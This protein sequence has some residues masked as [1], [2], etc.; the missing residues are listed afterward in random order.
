[1]A[2]N[3]FRNDSYLPENEITANFWIVLTNQLNIS[4]SEKL[5]TDAY[6][7]IAENL[8]EYPFSLTDRIGSEIN[9][10]WPADE[11]NHPNL[12][13][14]SVAIQETCASGAFNNF[15]SLKFVPKVG[16]TFAPNKPFPLFLKR[17]LD[18][19][20]RVALRS[21]SVNPIRSDSE[22]RSSDSDRISDS[23]KSEVPIRGLK[24]ENFYH[25]DPF[26]LRL[27]VVCAQII[28]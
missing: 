6:F 13:L 8:P 22:I 26:F 11:H 4:F 3:L 21:V 17:E 9:I 7:S 28:L 18:P 20:T 24:N 10:F 12:S 5:P 2:I 1:M 25:F 16:E 27:S 15:T 23:G 19:V 14:A